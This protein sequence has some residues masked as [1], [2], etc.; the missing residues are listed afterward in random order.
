M[1]ERRTPIIRDR[2]VCPVCSRT[3]R[4]EHKIVHGKYRPL[5]FGTKCEHYK[6]LNYENGT[7]YVVWSA[8]NA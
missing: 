4:F 1:A 5:L 2:S 6:T 8:S 3:I 7:W